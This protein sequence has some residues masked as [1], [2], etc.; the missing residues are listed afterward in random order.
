M[1]QALVM[2][3]QNLY[4]TCFL[5]WKYYTREAVFYRKAL[6]RELNI[7]F[8]RWHFNAHRLRR[9]RTRMQKVT[10]TFYHE[11]I[12]WAFHRWYM[13]TRVNFDIRVVKWKGKTHRVLVM[14]G[15]LSKRDSD[16]LLGVKRD[17]LLLPRDA[18]GAS[19]N[20]YSGTRYAKEK[21]NEFRVQEHVYW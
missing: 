4:K 14:R 7:R 8:H 2:M 15:D 1:K 3:E 11:N 16:G 19:S 12:H 9:L 10:V 18:R 5:G 13:R 6:H 20:A 21:Q 17:A